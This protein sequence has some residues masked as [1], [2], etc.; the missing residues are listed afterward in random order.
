MKK[1]KSIFYYLRYKNLSA[2]ILSLNAQ[3]SL[4]NT[5][6]MYIFYTA[7]CVGLGALLKLKPTCLIIV[8]G[9]S[10]L[11]APYIVFC[12]YKNEFEQKRFSDVSQYMQQLLYSFRSTGSIKT[13]LQDTMTI[14]ESSSYMNKLIQEALVILDSPNYSKDATRAAFEV[15][16]K[17]FACERLFTIHDFLEKAEKNGGD[18]GK[19]IDLLLI[20]RTFWVDRKAL[21]QA[22]KKEKKIEN[23]GC[24]FLTIFLCCFMKII[25]ME[26]DYTK[27]MLFQITGV[28][29][30]IFD[31][32]VYVLTC[33]EMT[34]GW[35]S[36]R[37]IYE[38]KTTM[39]YYEYVVNYDEKREKRKSY[40]WLVVP[41]I[42]LILGL[43][44]HKHLLSIVGGLLI[45][46]MLYQHR[47]K[48]S[49]YMKALRKEIQLK[50]PRWLMEITLLLQTMNVQ[51]AIFSS[52]E[53][54]P[55]VLVPELNKFKESLMRDPTSATPYLEFM[56]SFKIPEITASMNMLYSLSQGQGME[57]DEDSQKELAEII[58]RNNNL[59]NQAEKKADKQALLVFAAYFSMPQLSACI[60]MMVIILL[61]TMGSFSV[62]SNLG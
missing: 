17:E 1:G 53:N 9:S 30:I 50:F 23:I 2:E 24:I 39:T 38:E 44:T 36:E 14:F 37:E 4:K 32:I 3:I 35:L 40:M 46:V 25:P 43:F 47:I 18:Y 45:P 19:T 56:R 29:M 10:L 15:I 12:S 42:L 48:Y 33:R 26:Y 54:A 27:H 28:T 11:F 41:G 7:V 52:I 34:V 21:F 22:K 49:L 59:L 13:S 16:E 51:K 62:M 60:M 20:D 8:A 55:I 31:L 58:N 61:S 5:M 6:L 57:R